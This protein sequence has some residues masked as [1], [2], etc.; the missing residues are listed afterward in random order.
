MP[1][2]SELALATE[3]IKQRAPD[4]KS[5]K[6]SLSRLVWH[7]HVDSEIQ[8]VLASY[9]GLRLTQGDLQCAFW[10]FWLSRGV[11]IPHHDWCSAWLYINVVWFFFFQ[12]RFLSMIF[13]F[14]FLPHFFHLA[15]GSLVARKGEGERILLLLHFSFVSALSLQRE[16]LEKQTNSTGETLYWLFYTLMLPLSRI[17]NVS[18]KWAEAA[19]YPQVY[20][21]PVEGGWSTLPC[22]K[23]HCDH[24]LPRLLKAFRCVNGFCTDTDVCSPFLSPLVKDMECGWTSEEALGAGPH[25][26]AG[27]WG[28]PPEVPVKAAADPRCHRSQEAAAAELLSHR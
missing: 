26:G 1:V 18:V 15:E 3:T 10:D 17:H 24:R 12:M 13:S 9:I 8:I 22:W 14:S 5:S 4:S 2:L 6:G 21:G 20:D 28:D 11:W 23:L 27:D 25:D 16:V 19:Q 7:L